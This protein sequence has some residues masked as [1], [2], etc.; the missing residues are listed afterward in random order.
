VSD[1]ILLFIGVAALAI[2]GLKVEIEAETVVA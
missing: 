2:P 1:P